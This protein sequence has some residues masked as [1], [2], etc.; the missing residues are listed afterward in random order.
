MNHETQLLTAFGLS[1][2]SAQ[3]Y[4]LLNSQGQL[5]VPTLASSL[6]LSRTA[7]YQAI[8][9]LLQYELIETYKQGR[10]AYYRTA[11]PS[12]L[13]ILLEQ[14]KRQE[15][16]QAQELE[17]LM[18]TLVMPY[19]LAFHKPGVRVFDG[20]EQIRT[21]LWQ[22]LES[23]EEILSFVEANVIE[24]HL[25][26][27]NREYVVER[28]KRQLLKKIIMTDTMES[29]KRE[30]T[31]KRRD[32]TELKYINPQKYPFKTSVQIW[33]NKVLYLT[34]TDSYKIGFLIEND[35]IADFH[36][37]LFRFVWNTID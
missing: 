3:V 2:T 32:F 36:K 16:Q 18:S 15:A 22:T 5:D 21:A 28:V 37:S 14:K 12:K 24:T 7:I 26:E 25:Q 29:R 27:L 8:A 23:K 9:P 20:E 34:L 1:E 19:N 11:H 33:E 31:L 13:S 10:S 30:L 6:S 17:G 35:I 4:L